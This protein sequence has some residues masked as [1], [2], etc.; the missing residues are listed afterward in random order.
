MKVL[1]KEPRKIKIKEGR[2]SKAPRCTK[3][4]VKIMKNSP[5]KIKPT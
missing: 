3:I 1:E 5:S 4:P 2:K